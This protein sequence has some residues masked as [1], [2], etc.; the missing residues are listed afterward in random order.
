MSNPWTRYLHPT[1]C[2]HAASRATLCHCGDGTE[3]AGEIGMT[4][5]QQEALDAAIALID[6][7]N[8]ENK[9]E[10]EF[11]FR[12]GQALGKLKAIRHEN[13]SAL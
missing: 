2:E 5:T 4:K 8:P 1:S 7:L 13:G 6:G 3:R 11:W 10:I 9:D 12:M